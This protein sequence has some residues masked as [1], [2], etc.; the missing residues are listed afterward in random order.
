MTSSPF[1]P[2]VWGV[3]AVVGIF[4]GPAVTPAA[5]SPPAADVEIR[6]TAA[7]IDREITPTLKAHVE[8]GRKTIETFF[9]KPF[10]QS[11]TVEVLPNRAAFDDY[12]QRRWKAPKTQ[13][14]MVASGVADRMV[15]LS[16]RVWKTEAV[17]HNPADDKHIR[18]LVA[19]ELVHVYHGQFNPRPDFDGMDDLGWFVEGL[20]VYVS[21]QLE[22]SHRNAG[23]D[24][25]AAG[26]A[27]T[28]L[29]DA[30]SGRYRYGVSGSLVEFID[31]RDGRKMIRKLLPAISNDEALKILGTTEA[32]FLDAWKARTADNH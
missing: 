25:I 12:V 18:D 31:R 19:H 21:G 13:K 24:A 5:E 15:I 1:R 30:W 11:F 10:K 20:A 8:A 14:W 16:P 32:K 29:A 27:P 26:K 2:V 17:E 4:G 9:G 3:A 28:R 6:F 22:R 23:R 7:D